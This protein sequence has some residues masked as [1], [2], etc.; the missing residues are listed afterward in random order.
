MELEAYRYGSL[1]RK[2]IVKNSEGR[3]PHAHYV[4]MYSRKFL[5]TKKRRR[6]DAY[7]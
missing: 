2:V 3:E 7:T 5:G 6:R 4:Y 1:S